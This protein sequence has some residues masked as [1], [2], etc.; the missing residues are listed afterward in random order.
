M[1]ASSTVLLYRISYF[2][3]EHQNSVLEIFRLGQKNFGSTYMEIFCSRLKQFSIFTSIFKTT[4]Q[5]SV[6]Q[7][8]QANKQ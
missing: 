5:G 8:T 7:R 1:A 4:K 3:T 2:Q 6:M